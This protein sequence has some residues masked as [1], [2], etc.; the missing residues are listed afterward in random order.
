MAGWEEEW[1]TGAEVE[2]E[3]MEAEGHRGSPTERSCQKSW[4]ILPRVTAV[5]PQ[6]RARERECW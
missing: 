5:R 1:P 4:K 6:E 2:A 3:A